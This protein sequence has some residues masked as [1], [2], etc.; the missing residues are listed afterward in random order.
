MTTANT[1]RPEL[2][3]L[4]WADG[5]IGA[6]LTRLSIP[7][8]E[9]AV[10]MVGAVNATGQALVSNGT[11][12]ADVIRLAAGAGFAPHTHPGHHVLAVIGG[13]GTITYGGR[14]YRTEA[15]QI[16]L[17]EGS[18][19]HAV[20]AISDHLILAVGAPHKRVD[21]AER[22][23]LV[24]YTEVLAPEGDLDC[25]ICGVSARLPERLHTLRCVHC[26]CAACVGVT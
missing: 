24:P 12:G 15:G 2:A 11:I 8:D 14:V 18:V 4:S 19:P 9:R 26:P 3:I 20:G 5:D 10:K 6:D 13:V 23:D 16:F 22:M 25:T 21:S 17:I 1:D 7:H